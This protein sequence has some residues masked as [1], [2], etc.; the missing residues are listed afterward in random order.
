MTLLPRRWWLK[1][2]AQGV[3]SVLPG[4]EAVQERLRR[5]SRRQLDPEYVMTKW[6]HVN[7]HLRAL[8]GDRRERAGAGGP[9]AGLR[10][11]ELGTGW[12]PIVAL[13]LALQGAQVLTVDT[14]PHL[15]RR[16]IHETLQL[17]V[18]LAEDNRI[19]L[20]VP[21]RLPAAREALS[22]GAPLPDVLAAAGVHPLVGDAGNLS[23][24]PQAQGCDLM[25]SN[26]TLE[27][28][29]PETLRAVF[30][31]FHRSA[32]P[33]ARMSHYIDLADHYAGFDPRLSELHF[34]S[35][36]DPAWRLANNRLHYQNRLRIGDYQRLHRETGWR[37]LHRRLT[38]RPR[39][40]LAGLRLVPPFEELPEAQLLVV[41]AHLVSQ[42]AGAATRSAD[43]SGRRRHARP[44]SAESGLDLDL[45][46][47][48]GPVRSLPGQHVGDL[49]QG[50]GRGHERA[51]VDIPGPVGGD[52]RLQGR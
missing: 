52:G 36:P 24:L 32:A 26:N 44:R 6:V 23:D 51:G 45:G 13:G 28:I 22:R 11:L 25:V 29:P 30:T 15:D 16:R 1:A 41:K 42:R 35:M 5:M 37:V 2:A 7:A 4:G 46:P 18:Q 27:H 10:V 12:Y 8:P 40:E 38:R 34:L 33:G 9:L 31:E 14:A 49:L 20:A 48:T 43:R 3:T 17:L 47:R 19:T 50:H 21:Q 39:S